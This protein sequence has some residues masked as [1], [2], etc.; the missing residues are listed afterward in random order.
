MKI[1]FDEEV[2]EENVEQFRKALIKERSPASVLETFA[3][4]GA[5]LVPVAV[6]QKRK[7]KYQTL[8]CVLLLFMEI[9]ISFFSC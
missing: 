4:S 6:D 8:K 3:F 7:D 5:A 9:F 1:G 2:G